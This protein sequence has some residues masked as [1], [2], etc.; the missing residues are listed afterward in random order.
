MPTQQ[1]C[2]GNEAFTMSRTTI[3]VAGA[4]LAA[5]KYNTKYLGTSTST[6]NYSKYKYKSKYRFLSMYLGTSTSTFNQVQVQVQVLLNR[7]YHSIKI[8]L[9]YFM[10]THLCRRMYIYR[11]K[12]Y[13]A[14]SLH[15]FFFYFM[16]VIHVMLKFKA[17]SLAE[18][19]ADYYY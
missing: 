17:L 19:L 13:S 18:S 6:W 2:S 9:K 8:F 10:N 15:W 1:P 3:T 11:K 12:N 14:T 4:G 16:N 7:I 5:F